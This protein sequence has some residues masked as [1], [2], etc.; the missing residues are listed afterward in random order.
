MVTQFVPG[1]FPANP[2]EKTGYVLEFHDEFEGTSLDTSKWLP[3]YLPHWSSRAA[4]SPH[5]EIANGTLSLQIVEGQRPWCPEF[6]GQVRCSALQSGTFSGAFGSD[7]GQLRF[8]DTCRVREVQENC[9]LYT[10]QYG[11]IE[12]RAKGLQSAGNHVSLFMI[13][14]EEEPQQSGEICLF[15]IVGSRTDDE[16]STIGYGVHPWYDPT[17][18]DE[19]FEERFAFNAAHFHIYAVEWTPS[20]IDFYIDNIKIRTIHQTIGYPMQFMLTIYEH[21]FEGAWTGPYD[22]AAAYPKKFDIDYIRVYQPIGGY[23]GNNTE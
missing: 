4:T 2:I 13:G 7:T 23:K 19:F 17:L 11:Y 10:P 12:I 18:N 3:F 8:S 22:S 6:D 16:G 1:D 5:Y 20:H 15:E 21:P 14:Y 9:Q